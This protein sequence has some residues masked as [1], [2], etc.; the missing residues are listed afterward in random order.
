[1]YQRTIGLIQTTIPTKRS[2]DIGCGRG[3]FPAILKRLGWDASGIEISPEAAEGARSNFGL[4]VF[5]GTVEEYAASSQAK[6]FSVVTA[7]DVIEH[8]PSPDAFVESAARLVE[9]G[10][11][12]IIDTP[13]AAAQNIVIKGTSWKGFNPFHIYLFT[14]DTLTA[15]LARHG[16]MV[17]LSISYGNVYTPIDLRDSV[18]HGLKRTGLL[19][20]A[21]RSFLALK[22]LTI[23]NSNPEPHIESAVS[24]IMSGP[25]Y[26]QTP[27]SQAPLSATKTGDNIVV[28]ARRSDSVL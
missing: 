6:T 20:Q 26:T 12:L 14:I 9:P 17:D 24:R 23:S 16:M 4:E 7:I 28:I 1:M 19:G 25:P 10:G 15:L 2:I 27:D 8:V 21:A 5:T 22:K 13:N 3:Y 11:R 18:L